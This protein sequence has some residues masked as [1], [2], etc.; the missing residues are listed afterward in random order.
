MKLFRSAIVL[1]IAVLM[2]AAASAQSR[3]SGRIA[4]KVVDEQGQPVADVVIKAQKTGET[5][6][7][8]G[9]T[10]AKGEW[11][12]ARVASGEWKLEF[13]K[14]GLETHQMTTQVVESDR[15]TLLNVA[16][17]KPAAAPAAAA[18]P[19]AAINAELQRAA[20]MMQSGDIPGARAIYEALYVKYP[21]PYQFPFAIATTYISEKNYPKALEYAK[22]AAEKD[23]ANV[24][25]K[26]L[27]AEILLDAGQKEEAVKLLNTVDLTQVKDPLVFM[28]AAIIMI[29]DGKGAEAVAF[30]DKLVVQFPNQHQIYYYRGRANLVATKLDAAKADLEKFVSVAPADSKEVADAKDL[31]AKLSKK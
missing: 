24:D 28:N 6:M 4:G 23:P 17:K 2:A 19:T 5:D 18:D 13:S 14:A 25:V 30:L 29:N 21:Q 12:I 3:G 9:K 10:N 16:M 8:D 15:G 31:I 26:L 20:G 27:N 22:I 1:L 11:A 7:F